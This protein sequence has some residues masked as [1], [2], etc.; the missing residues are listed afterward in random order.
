[1][2]RWGFPLIASTAGAI[3]WWTHQILTVH[4]APFDNWTDW[5]MLGIASICKIATL[6]SVP[7]VLNRVFAR[8][9]EDRF[10][11]IRASVLW[12]VV[13]VSLLVVLSLLRVPLA[14][15]LDND[16]VRYFPTRSTGFNAAG[17]LTP[18]LKQSILAWQTGRIFTIEALTLVLSAAWLGLIGWQS[19]RLGRIAPGIV[20]AVGAAVGIAAITQ[21]TGMLVWDYDIFM[22]GT[23]LPALSLDAMMPFVASDPATEV[24]FLAYFCLIW[25]SW[26]LDRFLLK[27]PSPQDA[28]PI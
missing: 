3:I 7:I 8:C 23:L 12:A 4:F 11:P 14:A 18:A 24:A 16:A 17:F 25:S 6:A 21:H 2:K 22:A 10:N 20:A 19:K 26:A 13:S 15:T 27:R 1:V 28:S 9:S 5:V